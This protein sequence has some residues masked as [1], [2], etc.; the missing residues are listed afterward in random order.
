MKCKGFTLAEVL[1]TLSIIGVV[2]SMTMPVLINRAGDKVLE[3]QR[4]KAQS[5]VAN[6]AKMLISQTSDVYLSETDLKS[7]GNNSNCIANEIKKVFKV[8]DDNSSANS[9]YD[10]KYIF[11]NGEFSIW[12]DSGMNYVFITSDGMIFGVSQNN[13][14]S[15]SLTVYG[16]VNGLRAPNKGSKDV[17]IYFVADSGTVVENCPSEFTKTCSAANFTACKK[18]ECQALG[19][20][21]A[22]VSYLADPNDGFC[23]KKMSHGGGTLP[24][25]FGRI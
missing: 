22:W 5:V 24:G 16:D 4:K 18:E 23:T 14:A 19:S 9:V 2:A 13:K 7:C 11:D 20:G 6:G 3:S 21:F 15:D 17:C 10:T 12:K 1:I 8:I 25:N